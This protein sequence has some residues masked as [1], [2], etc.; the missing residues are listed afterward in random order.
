MISS[1]G[2]RVCLQTGIS[3]ATVVLL[4]GACGTKTAATKQTTT[5]TT[6]PTTSTT[7]TTAS[8]Q[9]PTTTAAPT[10]TVAPTTT[11]MAPVPTTAPPASIRGAD[12]PCSS[13]ALLA[14]FQAS[15]QPTGVGDG[16]VTEGPPTCVDAVGAK[17]GL[18]KIDTIDGFA[19]AIFTGNADGGVVWAL[20]ASGSAPV[21]GNPCT[22]TQIPPDVIHAFASS[23]R[24]ACAN[25]IPHPNGQQ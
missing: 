18:Q 10:S 19:T 20:V 21:T 3:L 25:I 1:G 15:A 24:R 7:E 22:E 14:A 8:P 5:S 12:L 23:G 11:T 6:Q 2:Y 16:A 9:L 17:W 13:T 4:F